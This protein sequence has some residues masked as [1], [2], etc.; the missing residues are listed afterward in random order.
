VKREIYKTLLDNNFSNF[1]SNPI[2]MD[3]QLRRQ[4]IADLLTSSFDLDLLTC[5]AVWDELTCDEQMTL[6]DLID[7]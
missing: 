1:N 6:A 3:K 5:T 2:P 7:C 4:L